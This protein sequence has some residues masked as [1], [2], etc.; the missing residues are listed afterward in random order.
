VVQAFAQPD[1][2]RSEGAKVPRGAVLEGPTGVGKT[3]LVHAMMNEIRAATGREVPYIPLRVGKVLEYRWGLEEKKLAGVFEYALRAGE[4]VIFIDEI[5]AMV[6][7]RRHSDSHAN[8]RLF[9]VL[10]TGMDDLAKSGANV[11]VIAA[12]NY[13]DSIDSALLSR[14]GRVIKV[15]PP[16]DDARR[17]IFDIH[18]N[19]AEQLAGRELFS[20]DFDINSF[21][22]ETKKLGFNGRDI[23]E[24]VQ[25]LVRAN[26]DIRLRGETP[27]L[28]TTDA[29]REAVKAYEAIRKQNEPLGYATPG[30]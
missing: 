16:D 25:R 2:Y 9:S 26:V 4:A 12:S 14:F 29:V 5:D 23:E 7:D 17:A 22:T 8:D 20:P 30:S 11:V 27:P 18:R 19:N 28:I 10:A 24:I 21:V 1:V 13:P 6:R 15:P 3:L